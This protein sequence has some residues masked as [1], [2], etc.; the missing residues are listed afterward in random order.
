MACR[1]QLSKSNVFDPLE[2]TYTLASIE[3]MTSSFTYEWI[4]YDWIVEK[5]GICIK[6]KYKMTGNNNT[7]SL[8]FKT[9]FGHKTMV[10]E[11][12]GNHGHTWKNG[13][14]TYKPEEMF[15][16]TKLFFIVFV[17]LFVN[18]FIRFRVLKENN[19]CRL[20]Y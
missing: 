6:F 3:N 18:S 12:H 14:V 7:L 1:E 4:S 2:K 20:I 9:L 13:F 17:C 5:A 8:S 15:A 19:S 11:L 10:W 16:V